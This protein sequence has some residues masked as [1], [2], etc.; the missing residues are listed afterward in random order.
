MGVLFHKSGL[1]TTVQDTGR[2]G[3]QKDG[4]S[5]SGIMDS[6]SARIA[7]ILVD[8]PEHEAVIEFMLVGPTIEFT[9]DTIIAITGGDFEPTINGKPAPMYTA[10]YVNEGD[11]LELKFARTGI[12]GY[13]A[14][15]SR[16][17][18]PVVMG[19]RS[20]NLK[21]GIGGF[22]GRKLEKDDQI[23]FRAKKL[24]IP[25]FLSRTIPEDDFSQ[26]E[27]TIRVI[28]G[29]QDDYFT[30]KGIKTFLESEFVITSESDRMGF[31]LDGPEIEHKKGSDIISDGIPMGAIQVP[32]HGK[33]IIMLA[34]RQTTGGYAKIATVASVDIPKLVQSREGTRIRFKAISVNDAQM[35]Y[36]KEERAFDKIREIIHRPCREV[37]EPRITARRIMQLFND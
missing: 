24:Y 11:I 32:A 20:T 23:W 14:F 2:T 19:S 35:E 13:I 7:N 30:K 8:N 27:K 21:C 29:P 36:K 28:S 3:F 4:F 31:R 15:S 6:R 16:L 34:D 33:P 10:I 5:V 26:S 12:W 1:M 17:D 9:F 37:I 18:V 25:S 22:H